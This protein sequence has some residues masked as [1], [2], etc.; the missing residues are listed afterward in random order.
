MQNF[1]KIFQTVQ[2]LSTF[3]TNRPGTKSSQTDGWQNLHKR[4]GDKIICLIIGHSMK[5]SFKFQLTFLGSCNFTCSEWK[6]MLYLDSNTCLFIHT[7][8]KK[9]SELV[10]PADQKVWSAAQNYWSLW[11]K[12]T[13]AE[14]YCRSKFNS[15][16][17]FTE[18]ICV[19]LRLNVPVNN[20][21]VMSGRSHR[22]LGN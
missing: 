13:Q 4:S 16:N 17:S 7:L 2:A 21:S 5:F 12:C 19:V 22:F 3:F 1:I 15:P 20:S 11:S 9:P 6:T 8:S 10:K 14:L 18:E